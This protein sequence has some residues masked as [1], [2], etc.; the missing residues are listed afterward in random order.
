MM[1]VKVNRTV[2]VIRTE[3]MI[4]THEVIRWCWVGVG[5]GS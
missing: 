4:Q 1:V 5:V 3:E 2:G